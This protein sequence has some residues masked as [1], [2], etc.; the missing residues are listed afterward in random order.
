MIIGVPKEI[1]DGEFRVAMV[2]DTV[3][4]LIKSG[5]QVV[6]EKD[7]GS[8]AHFLNEDYEKAGATLAASAK[9]VYEKADVILKVGRPDVHPVTGKPEV[10]MMKKGGLLIALAFVMAYPESAAACAS[11]GIDFISMDM[12]PRTTKAQRMDALSSQANLAGYKSVLLAANEFGRIFPLLM[13]AA[14]TITPARVVIMGAG[15]AGLQA[16]GTAKRLGAVVEVSDVRLAVKEEVMSLGGK[17]IEVEGMA[18][19]QDERGYA[20]EASPEFLQRQKDVIS[21]HVSNADIVITTALIPGRKAPV[22]VT[23]AMI[24]SM[25]PGSVVLDMAVEFGG[26]VEGSE[27]GKTVVKHGVKIIGHANLPALL[28]TQSSDLYSKNLL[29]LLGHI[30]KNG[31]VTLDL[32][33]EIVKGALIV[34]QG[35]IINQRVAPLLTK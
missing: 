2:P 26:N 32:N 24:K 5:F 14:G 28:S 18:D 7:A 30:S 34:H 21:K 19:L 15:V 6:V 22:L 20:K 29:A 25:K 16:L 17:F 12:V 35:Q 10:E 8:S 13:T 31:E 11:A 23:E 33:D 27:K 4:K 3:A 9:E 1:L